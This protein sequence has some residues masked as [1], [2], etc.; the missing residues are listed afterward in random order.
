MTKGFA[1][2]G[3]IRPDGLDC[4]VGEILKKNAAEDWNCAPDATGSVTADSLDFIDFE[5]A[6]NLD[7]AD[8]TITGGLFALTFDHASVSGD[9][10]LTGAGSNLGINAGDVID[11]MFEVGGTASIS[12][13]FTFGN[14]SATGAV[15]TSD[16]DISTTGAITNATYEG[17]I[18]T[19]TTGTLTVTNGKTLTV[20][21]STTLGT[22][23]I[24]LAG[25]EVITFTAANAV[26][27]TTTGPTTV[28]LPTSG[29]L[30]ILGANTFTGLQS[31]GAGA[32]SS[33]PFVFDVN[34]ARAFVV[35]DGTGGYSD[36]IFTVDTTASATNPGIDIVATNRTIVNGGTS[37]LTISVIASTSVS[38]PHGVLWV[39]D[40]LSN[41]LASMSN[42]GS[43]AL[44]GYI[45]AHGALV[46]CASLHTGQCVDLAEN[47]PTADSTI[48]AGD[49]VS[50]DGSNPIH[51]SKATKGGNVIGIISTKP[52]ILLTGDEVLTGA[53]VV[54]EEGQVPVALAGRV[55]VKVSTEN[56]PIEI[57]DFLTISSTPGVAMKA[58]K[59]G[60]AVGQAMDSYSGTEVGS[61]IAFVNT[62]FFN[63]SSL[64]S[65]V[66]GLDSLTPGSNGLAQALI[67]QF[68]QQDIASGSLSD[69]F[70]DRIAAGV[71]IISPKVF[72]DT[73]FTSNI[74]TLTGNSAITF[75]EDGNA[76][77]IGDIV[78]NTITADIPGLDT[79]NTELSA[80]S[81]QVSGLQS[82]ATINNL[83]VGSVLLANTFATSG[84]A[85]FSSSVH[86]GGG[87][88]VVGSTSFSTI[89][90]GK[91]IADEIQSQQLTNFQDKL[92]SLSTDFSQLASSSQ[93]LNSI[94]AT[95]ASKQLA[96]E[97]ILNISNSLT[98]N[99]I[100]TL[101]GGL[102]VNTISSN[103]EAMSILTDV[104]F[105]GRPYFNS[106]MGGFIVI[107][108]DATY[109]SVSFESEYLSQPVVNVTI[110][111]NTASAS[112]ADEQLLFD[113]D[114]R[115]IVTNKNT[116]G[117]TVK[118]N[119]P[120]PIGIQFS[121]MA[122]AIKDAKTVFS[123][124]VLPISI[125]TPE[126]TPTPESDIEASPTPSTTPELTPEP[127]PGPTPEPSPEITPEPELTP[128]P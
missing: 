122:L 19:T 2:F 51:V 115:F 50:T 105:F 28:T 67:F 34:S 54:Y 64:E 42:A 7:D 118:I 46:A 10:E 44:R 77:F 29:T 35:G 12:G 86:I 119:K 111:L 48:G 21:D 112:E 95:I 104:I 121:W 13:A 33:T 93:N 61:I 65:I 82:N 96:M 25:G 9:F 66:T 92:A 15:N 63:G 45:S 17:L 76:T 4:A 49:V 87:L 89:T 91:I 84:L 18:I 81:S 103:G 5:T 74:N 62:G 108:E 113:S 56:G 43:L 72:A 20:S 11:T 55:P 22:D 109:A 27:F 41:T 101:E 68:N 26:T 36:D 32:S 107:T 88:S 125:P 60:Y 59:A 94:F 99:G 1:F 16:W 14:S 114:I 116:K 97:D 39:T 6:L 79:I 31:F 47:Y 58:T 120:A 57:G 53:G 37:A 69:I 8:T 127:T 128:E 30:A 106:D 23:S 126:P 123:P 24:T 80:L 117:F 102:V 90:V 71:E 110:S 78:A 73:L 70:T 83:T 38:I 52:G 98:V 85:E 75:D 100:S 40:N 124:I 3:E